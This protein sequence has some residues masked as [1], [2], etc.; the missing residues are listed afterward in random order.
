MRRL[1]SFLALVALALYGL[2]IWLFLLRPD[3]RLPTAPAAAVV[4]L[5]GS[6]DR[7]PVAL[8][9]MRH[10][11]ATTLVVSET[12]ASNDPARYRL[13]NGPKPHGYRLICQN[14]DPFSTRGEARLAGQLASR[15][16]W[17]SLIV[18]SSRYQLYR[19]HVLFARCT[20]ATLVM[21]GTDADKW[22]TKAIAVP[23]E[24]VKLARAVTFQR[25]C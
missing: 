11:A 8:D 4:V 14:A 25:G 15:N 7:L 12:S 13:C 3:D 24:W 5:A 18:V 19:A 2:G 16:H 23:L 6:T 22:W 21:R 17:L 1:L 10:H 9:L 20:S